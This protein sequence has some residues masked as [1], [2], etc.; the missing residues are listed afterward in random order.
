MATRQHRQQVYTKDRNFDPPGPRLSTI[1]PPVLHGDNPDYYYDQHG[2]LRTRDNS[3]FWSEMEIFGKFPVLAQAPSHG[4]YFLLFFS[5][6]GNVRALS[7]VL[8][9]MTHLTSLYVNNNKLSRIPA[10]I[11]K[12]QNLEVLELSNNVIRQLPPE[13]G[14]M[15]NLRELHLNNNALRTLPCELGRLFQLR[16]LSMVARDLHE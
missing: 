16:Q 1:A 14:D 2:M 13:I 9:S 4:F 12:L 15:P 6:S 7:P 5:L 10:D 8:F 11:S 3:T